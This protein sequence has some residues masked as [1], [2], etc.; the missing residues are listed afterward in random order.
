VK[1]NQ[2]KLQYGSAGA[3]SATH[4]ACLLLNYRMRTNVTHVP[5]RGAGPALQDLIAGRIDFM[6]EVIST[7]L[8]PVQSKLVKPIALLST[9]RASVL[10]QL[11]TALEQGLPDV[12]ADGWNA[13]FF[14]KGTP[15]PIIRRLNAATDKALGNPALS[16][17]MEELGLTVPPAERRTPEHLAELGT[18]G[19]RQMGA[20]DQSERIQRGLSS[21]LS[22]AVSQQDERAVV[23]TPPFDL[24]ESLRCRKA[25]FG[26]LFHD[27]Q[28]AGRQ[29]ST[30]SRRGESLFGKAAAVRR[31]EESHGERLDRMRRP[32]LGGIA[33]KDAG[34]A[35]QP[36]GRHVLAQ[37]RSGLRSLVDEQ[38]KCRAAGQRLEPERARPGKEI[39]HARIRDGI[40]VGMDENVE[41]RLP[42]PIGGRPDRL[43]RRGRE[44]AP[45]QTPAD[46]AHQRLLPGGDRRPRAFFSRRASS[47]W[48]KRS[49]SRW[50]FLRVRGGRLRAPASK[51]AGR[52]RASGDAGAER[53][54]RLRGSP[55][56]PVAG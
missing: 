19:D 49:A 41:Q 2:D 44:Q 27:H 35:A 23:V 50:R 30:G 56:A 53:P 7:G 34:G 55:C 21:S 29:P 1:A 40:A 37:Q 31:I 54:T 20:T 52:T 17:R 38:S 22:D 15:E 6:C 16:V 18:D 10:P 11:P 33:P 42:Q 12:D 36:Q 48:P 4:I 47:G 39:E 8:P 32:E 14:P 28:R 51:A 13:F 25:G 46:D 24:V 43:R 5:Y 45:A 3:G 26:G 9:R